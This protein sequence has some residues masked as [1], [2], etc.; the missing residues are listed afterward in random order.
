MASNDSSTEVPLAAS[1]TMRSQARGERRFIDRRH[2]VG[3]VVNLADRGVKTGRPAVRQNQYLS[4]GSASRMA[5]KVNRHCAAE[6]VSASLN[7]AQIDST[8]PEDS[9]RNTGSPQ[10]TS[11]LPATTAAGTWGSNAS[12]RPP[13]LHQ[14]GISSSDG[15]GCRTARSFG[16]RQDGELRSDPLRYTLCLRVTGCRAQAR[17]PSRDPA[18]TR[19]TT[20]RRRALQVG[21]LERRLPIVIEACD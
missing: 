4:T 19:S 3:Y 12:S 17:G 2:Q 15:A 18:S 1:P 21:I 16:Y 14:S 6:P 9:N 11:A 7:R 10:R 8:R 13:D 5:R 20:D